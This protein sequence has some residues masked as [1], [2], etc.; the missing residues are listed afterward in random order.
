[1]SYVSR[2]ELS[3]KHLGAGEFLHG[4]ANAALDKPMPAALLGVGALWVLSRDIAARAGAPSLNA[5]GTS[6]D[7][8]TTQAPHR[9]ASRAQT[10]S[11]KVI[12]GARVAQRS[13]TDLWDQQPLLFGV[14]GLA[15]GAG[16]AAFL[17]T[18]AV[19]A[20]LLGPQAKRLAAQTKDFVA[21]KVPQ[22]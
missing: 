10:V 1:M 3:S 22:A 6:I 2:E 18:T 14:V 12:Q 21:A 9:V 7:A 19:E 8:E 16:V 17:P 20:D 5:G 15:I 13:V 11:E 4:L